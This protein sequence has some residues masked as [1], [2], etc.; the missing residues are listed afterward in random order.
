M[1]EELVPTPVHILKQFTKSGVYPAVT[2]RDIDLN[3]HYTL[4]YGELAQLVLDGIHFS[5]S[6]GLKKG[7]TIAYLFENSPEIIIL[8]LICFFA[9]LKACPLDIKRDTGD[10][11]VRK[12]T[13]TN[14]KLFFYRKKGDFDIP[15]IATLFSVSDA[16]ALKDIFNT[17]RGTR[18]TNLFSDF[19]A[20]D[21][22]MVLYTSGTTGFPKG[23]QLSFRNLFYGSA[24]VR[25][26]FDIT[27]KD[28]F[29]V[30]L[31]LHHIN[32]TIF[33]LS[34]LLAG[35]TLV[36][37]SRYSH[38]HFF[39]DLSAF[40]ITMSSIVPTI[41]IDLLEE[42][43]EYKKVQEQ[44]RMKRIQI[45]SAPVS[46]KHTVEFVTKYNIPLIQGYGSTE[47][48]LRVT[49]VPIHVP[50][51]TYMK[52]LEEN[53]IG[54]PLKY[55][56]VR[57][58]ET[59]EILVSGKNITRGYL[60]REKETEEAIKNGEFYTGDMGYTKEIDGDTYYFLKGRIKEII[61]KGGVNISPLF[62]EEKMR[63]A[64]PWA[65]DIVVVGFP[66]YRF[67]EEIGVVII[68]KDGYSDEDVEQVKHMCM[69]NNVPRLSPFETPRAVIIKKDS[70]IAKTA[71]GKVQ[72][73]KVRD[74]FREDMLNA[75]TYLGKNSEWT[76]RIILPDEEKLDTDI[77]SIHNT[78]FPFAPMTKETLHHRLQNGFVI[79]AFDA[80]QKLCGVLTGFFAEKKLLE[81]GKNWDDITGHGTFGTASTKG[82]SAILVSA[83]SVNAKTEMKQVDA[84]NV[85][86]VSE[87]TIR[88]YIE[89][90]K[91]FVVRFH[92]APKGGMEKGAKL[93]RIL[94]NGNIQD[95]ESLGCVVILEYELLN[96]MPIVT[97][98]GNKI[99]TGLVE[100][101][102][103][104]AWQNGKTSAF[105]LSRL[106]EAYKHIK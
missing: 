26:W 17:A 7:D 46:A 44:L 78:G 40:H 65:R 96:E 53:S 20:E 103:R 28:T 48:S 13:E 104:Y 62:I 77:L 29:Y 81:T 42:E 57:L 92:M 69:S 106:G 41:V 76:Y 19:D 15:T 71:T 59:N 31:P 66:H 75:Y 100:A 98:S 52:L 1:Y 22:G 102:L 72:H 93:F 58:S 51:K 4:T 39:A 87:E 61:I 99:G 79:G 30:V 68:P 49:G 8:N 24:Q 88:S 34:T 105:P 47:T 70:D 82:K 23:A 18:S 27:D 97:T 95:I 73:T 85:G 14:A 80:K 10:V 89:T 90:K 63:E 37:P 33:A 9:G 12:L 54:V 21:V 74:D 67:G 16:K 32:S 91:D 3:T 84:L 35:G 38:S 36:I 64:I 56:T 25:E 94:P 43:E 6:N 101:G 11:I 2:Y 60:H 55:N 83:A 86:T 5:V 50:K 45:G